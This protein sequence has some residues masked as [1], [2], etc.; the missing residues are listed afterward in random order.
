M[1]ILKL[2]KEYWV[3]ITFLLGFISTFF[4]F[5]FAMIEG[6]KCTLKN[7]ILSIYDRCKDSKKITHYQ[8]EAILCSYRF[9]KLLRG[10]SFV[11]DVVERVKKFELIE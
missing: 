8:L 1:E 11:A 5:V 4:M 10:N 3:L 6:I 7:D 2:I 9:Y